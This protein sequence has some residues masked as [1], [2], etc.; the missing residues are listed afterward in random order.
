MFSKINSSQ[1][2]NSLPVIGFLSLIYIFG[3]WVSGKL[4]TGFWGSYLLPSVLWLVMAAGI[5]YYLPKG[6]PAIR[7]RHKALFNWAALLCA[8][9]GIG[10]LYA[11]GLFSG[12]GKSPYDHSFTGILINI[13]YLGSTLIG[14][15]MA[16]AYLINNIFK[17]RSALGVAVTAIIFTFFAF[18]PGRLFTF[19]TTL[20]GATFA[21]NIFLPTLSENLLASYLAFL[22][23]VVPALIYRG[24]ML[25]AQWF[26]PILPDLSWL[27]KAV[28]GTFIPAFCM[29]LLHQLHQTEVLRVRRKKD[30]E[31]PAGW[32]TVSAISVLVV[33]FAVGVFNIFPNVI[34]SGSMS[35]EIEVGDIVLVKR[36]LP[37]EVQ[38]ND[39][40]MFREDSV[41]ISHRVIDVKEDE[42]GLPLF[43]TKGDANNSP[44]SD[45]VIAEQLLGKVVQIV[46]KVG[47]ITIMLRNPG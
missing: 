9:A 33:W 2:K 40:I 36:I 14:M 30:T 34:I 35:P 11:A 41:R 1:L 47:W 44:D 20:D 23:G 17:K 27:V 46:P 38:L 6:R 39:V 29:V 43:V 37:E 3:N 24:L 4:I 16:R 42:R 25:A 12:L 45:P 8:I 22:G 28:V 19:E 7:G 21:G 15:E 32:V 10:S 31:N 13:F 18:S 26:A 5:Y